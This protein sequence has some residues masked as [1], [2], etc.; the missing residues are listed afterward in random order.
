MKVLIAEDDPVS[1]FILQ[2]AVQ[3]SGHQ[4]L[5][6]EDGEQGWRFFQETADVDVVISD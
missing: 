5:T 1:R 2:T 3:T 6:A 4:T